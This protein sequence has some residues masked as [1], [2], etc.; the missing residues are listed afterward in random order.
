MHRSALGLTLLLCLPATAGAAVAAGSYSGTSSQGDIFRYGDT[1]PRTDKGKVT[2]S[3]KGA[4]VSKFKLS[5]QEIM[6]GAGPAPVPMSVAKIKLSSAGKGKATYTDPNVGDFA[7]A[8]RVTS[9]GRA[10]GTITPKGLCRGVVK[11]TAKR[12]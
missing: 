5:G 12:R 7:I 4:T 1:E 6:C 10:S 3:V 2:F 9:A 11:F 8:I